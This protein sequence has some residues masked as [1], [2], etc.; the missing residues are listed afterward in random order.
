LG[1]G[2]GNVTAKGLDSAADDDL[3]H[4]EAGNALQPF[5]PARHGLPAVDLRPEDFRVPGLK[6]LGDGSAADNGQNETEYRQS[7][8]CC[9]AMGEQHADVMG[10]LGAKPAPNNDGASQIGVEHD[11][12]DHQE[13]DEAK[14]EHRGEL[15][16]AVDDVELT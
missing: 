3:Q 10:R 14:G 7:G 4:H 13:R 9:P 12:K 1:A 11:R 6:H 15:Q 8:G 16:R 5:S 2:S